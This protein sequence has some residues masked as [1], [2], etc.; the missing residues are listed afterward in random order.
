M[1]RP[2]RRPTSNE[3][4]D[5][6]TVE[7]QTEGENQN[8]AGQNQQTTNAVQ[9]AINSIPSTVSTHPEEPCPST[10]TQEATAST[11]E[12][13]ITI[14]DPVPGDDSTTTPTVP[15]IAETV[16]E[17][18]EDHTAVNPSDA[19]ETT[20]EN[21]AAEELTDDVSG[22][23][24][25]G[26]TTVTEVTTTSQTTTFPTISILRTTSANGETN[27]VP[28]PSLGNVGDTVM[29]LSNNPVVE[30]RGDTALL[31][32]AQ[33]SVTSNTT[34]TK[35]TTSQYTSHNDSQ[36]DY[37]SL[38]TTSSTVDDVNLN[39]SA[40]VAGQRYVKKGGYAASVFGDDAIETPFV[41]VEYNSRDNSSFFGLGV[42]YTF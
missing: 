12:I 34:T 32:S 23:D 15:S 42:A 26:E 18:I 2:K 29:E 5:P 27:T 28:T 38:M 8:A 11:P 41:Q 22:Q 33:V 4:I 1:G 31:V 19:P 20:V 39:I 16:Q 35:E 7:V 25:Q 10:K 9:N 36:S 24:A 21:P 30:E 17:T 14:S 37:L 13:N 6:S 3:V 40:T